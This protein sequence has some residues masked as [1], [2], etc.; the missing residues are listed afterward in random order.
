MRIALLSEGQFWEGWQSLSITK[1]MDSATHTLAMTTTDRFQEGLDRWNILGGSL[2]Y[3]FFDETPVFVGYVQRYD[4]SIGPE[5]HS[6]SI[7]AASLAIDAVQCSHKGPYFWKD[8]TA[9]QIISD[10]LTPFE[11]DFSIEAPLAAIPAEGFRVGVNETPFS[12]V[13]KLAEK[14]RLITFTRT[15][16]TLVLS[17]FTANGPVQEIRRGDYI[18]ASTSSDLTNSFSEIIVKAQSNDR[19][20]N[21]AANQRLER[22]ITNPAQTRYRP[23]VFLSNGK[24]ET[25]ENLAEYVRERFAE[26]TLS[27]SVTLKS[28]YRPDGLIWD[29]E[30]RVFLDE[31]LLD[32]NQELA[33]S[34]VNF[35]MSED[36]GFTTTLQLVIP[37]SVGGEAATGR[38]LRVAGNEFRQLSESLA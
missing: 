31:P 15:D 21:F 37:R 38:Q 34:E 30:N 2:I 36:E 25:Q 33:V 14:N 22:T 8:A 3:L 32:S 12:I 4:P 29:I 17:R 10:V 19:E 27:A 7:E 1:S 13:K 16:G 18:N 20:K 5:E 23:L 28:A 9:E 6:I 26:V 11:V 35:S 24:E